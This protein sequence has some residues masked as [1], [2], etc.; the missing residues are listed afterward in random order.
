M[1]DFDSIQTKLQPVFQKYHI[2]KALLFGSY[3]KGTARE[4]SDVDLCVDSKLR[5]L[6]FVGFTEEVR[7]ALQKEVDVFDVSHI[8]AGSQ[9]AQEIKDTGVLI[10]G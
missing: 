6:K 10:Y 3:A 4:T 2:Q 5:G 1:K 7:A 9:V 8:E